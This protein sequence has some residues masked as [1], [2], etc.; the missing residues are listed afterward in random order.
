[1]NR[2]LVDV[3]AARMPIETLILIGQLTFSET[4]RG[5]IF[6]FAYDRY[7]FKSDYRLQI[8]PP[9][10]LHCGELYNDS[11]DKNFRAFLNS[12]P[13]R[14]GRVLMQRHAAIEHLR[15]IRATSRL[16]GLLNHYILR[17]Q[18]SLCEEISILVVI[19]RNSGRQCP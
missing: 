19:I 13:D 3:Y 15:G 10:T 9:L 2:T 18:I 1:M 5:G 6:S 14:W 12:S 7:F 17:R 4:S 11:P 8:D 16:T